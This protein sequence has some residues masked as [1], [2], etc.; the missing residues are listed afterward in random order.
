MKSFE[1]SVKE[2]F[3][4]FRL[5]FESSEGHIDNLANLLADKYL[6]RIASMEL[7]TKLDIGRFKGYKDWWK[8]DFP[9]FVL[10][11]MLD[12]CIERNDLLDIMTLCAMIHLREMVDGKQD[13]S[14][15]EAWL[16]EQ[17]EK[18]NKLQK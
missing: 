5:R 12:D 14:P 1:E 15:H 2:E 10:R 3:E 18:I 6:V 9:V 8:K 16:S 17:V 13:D 4:D 7:R 11:K